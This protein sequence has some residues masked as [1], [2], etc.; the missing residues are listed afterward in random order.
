MTNEELLMKIWD[1]VEYLNHKTTQM[2]TDLVWIK[3]LVMGICVAIGLQYITGI[4]KRFTNG[5]TVNK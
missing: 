4:Y 5:K 1:K 3:W 2:E